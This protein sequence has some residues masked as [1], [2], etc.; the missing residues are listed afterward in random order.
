M[1]WGSGL[2]TAEQKNEADWPI[3]AVTT[4]GVK[5]GSPEITLADQILSLCQVQCRIFDK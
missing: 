2:P 1:I 3:G 5:V 4:E